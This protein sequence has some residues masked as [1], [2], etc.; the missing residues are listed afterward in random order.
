MTKVDVTILGAG[1]YGLAAGAHLR[2]IKGLETRIFGEPMEFWKSYMPA[3]MFLRSPWSASTISD[4]ANA[5]TID[6]FSARQANRLPIPVPLDD[7]VRYGLWFR[8]NALP[9]LVTKKITRIERESQG[10]RVTSEAGETWNSRRVVVAAGLGSFARRPEVFSKLSPQFVTH[11][12]DQRDVER[13]RGKRV[14][15]IGAGQS[16]LES[17]ALVHE[18]GGTVEVLVREDNVHWL[19]WRAKMARLGPLFKLLYAPTDVGPAGV[20][21]IVA[22]PNSVKYFPRA[23]QNKFRTRSLRPAGARW[24]I[25]RTKHVTIS[26][27]RYVTSAEAQGQVLRLRLNDGSTREVDHVLLGTGYRVD[28]SRYPFLPPEIVQALRITDGFPHLKAGLESTVPGLHFMGA[29][30]AWNFGP[31]MYFVAGTD[32][33]ARELARG[34]LRSRGS[35]SGNS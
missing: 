5:L 2:K 14:A 29:P 35:G 3:G 1:P 13:F 9:D 7:F 12:S 8:E 30:S 28:V 34:I 21:R 20:S 16:A 27:S 10:F 33:G 32:F 18:A 6:A 24:L 19:G 15:I 17:A 23:L 11:C 31:L 4:P 26:T 25:E 22:I